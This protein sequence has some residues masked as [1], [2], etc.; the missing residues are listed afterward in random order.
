MRLMLA[1]SLTV[2]IA[3]SSVSSAQGPLGEL[4]DGK[5]PGNLSRLPDDQIEGTV[6]EYKAKLKSET[7]HAKLKDERESQQK[8]EA[9]EAD[10]LPPVVARL[11]N[12]QAK[13]E[14]QQEKVTDISGKFRTEGDAI[15]ALSRRLSLPKKADVQRDIR[16]LRAGELE[17]I[18]LP[19]RSS[20]KRIGQYHRLRSGKL[21]LEFDDKESLNGMM[22]IKKRKK[23]SDVW[24]GEY[25]E[26]EGR[27]LLRTWTVEV[28][29]IED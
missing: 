11:P 2:F 21:K 26:M 4:I 19:S 24:I 12:E 3:I 8:D 5:G 14:P 7:R 17:E 22:I 23:S 20:P 29:A 6:W 10:Q 25:R 27:K 18:K 9:K 16:K 15:F 28:R 13:E 1:Y